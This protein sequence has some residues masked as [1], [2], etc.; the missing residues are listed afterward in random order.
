MNKTKTEETKEILIP[1]F[2]LVV[3][4]LNFN[5]KITMPT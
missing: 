3:G 2:F 5:F 4:G 1:F